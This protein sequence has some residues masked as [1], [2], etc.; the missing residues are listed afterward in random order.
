MIDFILFVG[1]VLPI[2]VMLWLGVYLIYK[3]IKD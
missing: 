3:I 1:L 2:M